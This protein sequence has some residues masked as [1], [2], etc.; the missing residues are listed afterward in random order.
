MSIIMTAQGWRPLAP[1]YRGHG[2]YDCVEL[3]ARAPKPHHGS[4]REPYTGTFPTPQS[5]AYVKACQDYM[6]AGNDPQHISYETWMAIASA[7]TP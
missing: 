3:G 2:C 7:Q 4:A 6:R 1:L 5:K